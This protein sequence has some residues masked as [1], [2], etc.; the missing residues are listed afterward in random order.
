MLRV[1]VRFGLLCPHRRPPNGI[2]CAPTPAT[3]SST[4]DRS[5]HPHGG[6]GTLGSPVVA[7]L[8][9]AP[10]DANKPTPRA[11][12]IRDSLD[13]F[14]LPADRAVSRRVGRSA[15]A[16]TPRS[17]LGEFDPTKRT[18]SALERLRAQESDRVAALLP[19]RYTRMSAS[20]WSYLRGAAAVMAA[21]LAAA[22]HTGILVQLC[23]DAHI[24]NF[25][26]WASPEREL[27]FDARDFDETL[28]G[29]FEWDLKR[30]VTS[31]F[32][33]ARDNGIRARVAREAADAAVGA[34]VR[35]MRGYAKKGELD[36]WY[37]RIRADVPIEQLSGAA[38]SSAR[39]A[40]RRSAQKRSGAAAVRQL[41][42]LDDGRR[43]ISLAP[44]KRMALPLTPELDLDLAR[45]VL[46]TYDQSLPW[47]Q[48]RLL[49]RFSVHDGVQ[50]VVGV[51]SV[52]MRIL[53]VLLEG[54][55]GKQ[56]L[57]LQVKQAT[58]SVYEQ[59][60]EPSPFDNHG[61][62]VAVGQRLMQS[63]SDIFLGWTHVDGHDFYVRQ[64]RDMKIIPD[65]PTISP[66]LAAFAS[67]CAKALA[68]SHARSGDPSAIA[69]Y[70]GSDHAFRTAITDFAIAYARQTRRDHA[71][72]CAARD[73]LPQAPAD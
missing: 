64:F 15:R 41:T 37:D 14:H 6:A 59:F 9:S 51:G 4:V 25:G 55:S 62:R 53:L 70:I 34:Y 1:L 39:R 35:S 28:A 45:E 23:G 38:A 49:E 48:R 47:H 11:E 2:A 13:G 21:D 16:G 67:A 50:Q 68:K 27:L 24:L 5:A 43:T 22:E 65:G 10:T 69:A 54:Q 40:L 8:A 73:S 32:V 29:P 17:G 60:L 26:L 46:E 20:P 44:G 42:T 56:P 18:A 33:L 61:Q 7:K 30:L 12:E 52:G 31:I 72:L 36:I 63:A 71:E 58:A 19:E 3:G 57:L 66:H